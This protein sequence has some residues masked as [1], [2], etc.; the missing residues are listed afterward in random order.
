MPKPRDVCGNCEHWDAGVCRRF[1]PHVVLYAPDNKQPFVSF[2]TPWSPEVG[3]AHPACGEFS[4][5][6]P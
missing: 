5:V 2:P 4:K 1:P 6:A 3:A